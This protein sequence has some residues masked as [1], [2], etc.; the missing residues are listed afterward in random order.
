M[1]NQTP[2]QIPQP[3]EAPVVTGPVANPAPTPAPI[4]KP[5][6]IAAAL[7]NAV[8]SRTQRAE[9]SVMKSFAEQ[10][11]MS[12]Q[13]ASAILEKAKAEKAA[14][15]PEA[16]QARINEEKAKVEKLLIAAEVK[17]KGAALGLVD[18]DTALLLLDRSGVK[19]DEAGTVTGVDEALKHLQE[20]KPFLFAPQ[21]T[22]QTA[23]VGGKVKSTPPGDAGTVRDDIKK[24]LFGG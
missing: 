3:T 21:P 8:D 23:N 10:Y 19:V 20:A 5:E 7:L 16:A 9:R 6:E 4:V 12:E 24:Q 17:A 2:Q 14:Q 22:G 15:L 1:P 18:A 11:G 13:E